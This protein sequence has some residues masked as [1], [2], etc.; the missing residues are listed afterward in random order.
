MASK[1]K[2]K[3]GTPPPPRGGSSPRGSNRPAGEDRAKGPD[4][5]VVAL[6]VFSTALLFALLFSSIWV[7]EQIYEAL[8][9]GPL[10]RSRFVS[11]LFSLSIMLGGF[12]AVR[13]IS[14]SIGRRLRP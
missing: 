9:Y 3:R 8:P 14:T 2:S 5:R 1:K 11:A 4:R 12:M 10:P 6:S 13:G 7:G